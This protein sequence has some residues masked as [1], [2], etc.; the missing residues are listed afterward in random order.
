M[1]IPCPKCGE[2]VAP[3]PG[4]PP[5]GHLWCEHGSREV[6]DQTETSV[7]WNCRGGLYNTDVKSCTGEMDSGSENS[8]EDIT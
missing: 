1:T 4:A 3:P 2:P 6:V 8:D 7:T 5:T